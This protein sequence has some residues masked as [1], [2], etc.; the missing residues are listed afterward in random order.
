M[1]IS[2]PILRVIPYDIALRERSM[3]EWH[4]LNQIESESTGIGLI[5]I[6][7]CSWLFVGV[8][9]SKIYRLRQIPIAIARLIYSGTKLDH[10]TPHLHDKLHWLRF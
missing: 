5:R 3:E 10:V 4:E 2:I 6:C 1:L 7:R 9:R 8:T